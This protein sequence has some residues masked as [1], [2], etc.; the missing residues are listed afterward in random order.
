M[1]LCC[2]HTVN[3]GRGSRSNCLFLLR[4]PIPFPFPFHPIVPPQIVCESAI[5][6]IQL[7]SD[8]TIPVPIRRV[9]PAAPCPCTE[10]RNL[11]GPLH[12]WSPRVHGAASSWYTRVGSVSIRPRTGIRDLCATGTTKVR[13]RLCMYLRCTIHT[14]IS[15]C[16]HRHLHTSHTRA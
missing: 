5:S 7:H 14:Y 13:L 6:T 12:G 8:I 2:R 15:T 3:A 9:V 1:Q 4:S 16:L 11:Q 10:E